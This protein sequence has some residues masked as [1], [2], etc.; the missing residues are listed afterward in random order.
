MAAPDDCRYTKEHEWV[1]AEGNTAFVGITDYAQKQ[2][3]EVVFVDLPEVGREVNQGEEF[4]VVESTKAASDIYAPVSGTVAEVNEM[5]SESPDAINRDP[6]GDGWIAR[7]SLADPTEINA[8]LDA[9][10]YDA[11]VAEQE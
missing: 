11:F 5:L 2:L 7:L 6:Y 3:G 1:R 8:L 9:E 10:A 4:A